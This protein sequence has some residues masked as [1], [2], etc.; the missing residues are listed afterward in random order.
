MKRYQGST[1]ETKGDILY[2]YDELEAD[3][4]G[5]IPAMRYHEGQCQWTGTNKEL[6]DKHWERIRESVEL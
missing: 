3:D 1:K 4:K 5:T 6:L 2:V